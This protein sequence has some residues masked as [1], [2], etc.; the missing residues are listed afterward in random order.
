[1]KGD[2]LDDCMDA[3][4]YGLYTW[5]KEAVKPKELE[6]AEVMQGLDPTNAMIAKHKFDAQERQSRRSGEPIFVGPSA[7]RLRARYHA[8]LRRQQRRRR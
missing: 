8:A 2:P 6:R 1:V 3:F 4:R 7:A 5:I